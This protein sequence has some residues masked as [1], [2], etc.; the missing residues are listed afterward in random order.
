MRIHS[1]QLHTVLSDNGN[2]L[3]DFDYDMPAE[4]RPIFE[5]KFIDFYFYHCISFDSYH[6]FKHQ[7][8]ATLNALM[9]RYIKLYMSV[10]IVS[11]P[12][13]NFMVQ[14]DDWTRQRLRNQAYSTANNKN[15]NVSNNNS[16][17]IGSN[18][19]GQRETA[20]ESTFGRL[21]ESN[22]DK[23]IKEGSDSALNLF[24]DTPQI[25]QEEPSKFNDGYTTTKNRDE[26]RTT[27]IN[28][29]NIS[30][31]GNSS[32]QSTNDL[33]R[34]SVEFSQDSAQNTGLTQSQNYLDNHVVSGTQDTR[35][36]IVQE[37]GLKNKSVIEV[38]QEWRASF[39]NVDQLLINELR[40]LFLYVY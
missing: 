5:Q 20:L 27:E 23:S 3:F 13:V 12:F 14:N 2:N 17:R 9:P 18:R 1:T 37:Y 32:N 34:D 26:K 21:E 29:K 22:N 25:E 10:D 4:Y 6:M 30:N 40:D 39:I 28:S 15:I 8:R 24:S 31:T 16:S 35:K 11:N 33:S 7:L 38:V 36:R 19:G